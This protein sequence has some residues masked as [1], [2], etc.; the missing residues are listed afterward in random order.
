MISLQGARRAAQRGSIIDQDGGFHSQGVTPIQK[1]SRRRSDRDGQTDG[2]PRMNKGF[3]RQALSRQ[4]NRKFISGRCEERERLE[5]SGKRATQRQAS[6]ADVANQR[7]R[8]VE[9]VELGA[10]SGF[11]A[12]SRPVW[13]ATIAQA[14]SESAQNGGGA[15]TSLDWVCTVGVR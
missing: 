8:R 2:S 14:G 10:F 4:E 1:S 3:D 9:S 13:R 5:A 12:G 11:G 6:P 7:P 15:E